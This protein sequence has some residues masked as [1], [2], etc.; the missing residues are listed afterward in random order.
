MERTDGRPLSRRRLLKGA[1]LSAAGAAGLRGLLQAGKEETVPPPEDGQALDEITIAQLRERLD[2]GRLTARHL[3]EQY[4]ARIGALDRGRPGLNSVI[5]VN[6]DALRSRPARRGGAREA[7]RPAAR[8]S[9]SS[10]RTT[11]TPPTGWR[12]RPARWR[13]R[14]R[15]APRDAFVVERLRAAGAV[16]L[17]K[18]N[19]SEWANF[20]STHSTSGW[21]GR[22]GQTRNPYALDRN[23]CGSSSGSARG[24]GGEPVRR[25]GRHRDRRLDRLPVVGQRHRGHQADGRAGQP[26][27]HHSDLPQ[28]GHGRPDG[29]DGRRRGVAAGRRWRASIRG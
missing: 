19:L 12:P 29:A 24:R 7:A 18:T 23:P 15:I 10:S 28:A 22:G 8:Q 27:G 26:R 5:E 13:S 17:G 3:A 9:R 21:S 25:G 6:P 2:S 16:I 11:S 14:A 1:L 20:R 4:L